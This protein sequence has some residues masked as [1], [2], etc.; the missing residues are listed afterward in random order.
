MHCQLRTCVLRLL[1]VTLLIGC[2]TSRATAED[3]LWR[4][5]QCSGEV[6]VTASNQ[7]SIG[8]TKDALLTPG[9]T[10]ETGANGRVLLTRGE[11]TI[12][13][14]AN[15]IV[16]IPAELSPPE[17]KEGLSTT[18]LQRAGSILLNVKKRDVQ[19]FEVETPHLAAVVK[20]TQFRVTASDDNTRVAVL[21]GQVEVLDFKSGRYALVNPE[22]MA[23]VSVQ[24]PTGPTLSGAGTLSPI[25]QGTPRKSSVFP[26]SPFP[27]LGAADP[28]NLPSDRQARLTQP[29]N[30]MAP[31]A[32]PSKENTV[33]ENSRAA[34]SVA[35][36]KDHGALN[37]KALRSI[38]GEAARTL[39]VAFG[40]G[41]AVS[42]VVAARRR[43]K[44]PGH[45]GR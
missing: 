21:A 24:E 45:L 22:Q 2:L 11:E 38:D 4:V 14:S 41:I 17:R 12:L 42:M 43:R 33:K 19:R 35:L 25:R 27:K 36:A 9:D 15:S 26:V 32:A 16:G 44:R 39:A 10:V 13:I 31:V 29:Q 28:G 7:Q 23:E 6:F 5:G 34:S 8:L 30:E 1:L 37:G 18:I 20:G 40:V 3:L